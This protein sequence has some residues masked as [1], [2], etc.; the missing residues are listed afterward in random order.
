MSSLSCSRRAYR[1][2]TAGFAGIACFLREQATL[3]APVIDE[4]VLYLDCR[5]KRGGA[6]SPREEAYQ[7]LFVNVYIYISHT[8]RL[9]HHL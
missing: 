6:V 4:K 8:F 5:S 3:L 9:R 2:G 7:T 1:P